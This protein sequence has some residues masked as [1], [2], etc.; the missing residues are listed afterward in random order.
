MGN[1]RAK[2]DGSGRRV[3][4]PSRARAVMGPEW[5]PLLLVALGHFLELFQNGIHVTMRPNDAVLQ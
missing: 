2:S 5:L 1:V 4:L 3:S